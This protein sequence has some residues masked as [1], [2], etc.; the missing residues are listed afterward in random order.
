[1]RPLLRDLP[2]AAVPSPEQKARWERQRRT[3]G[4]DRSRQG[5]EAH[6]P[7]RTLASIAPSASTRAAGSARP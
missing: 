6:F 3:A 5:D 4:I 1:M 2:E 7:L